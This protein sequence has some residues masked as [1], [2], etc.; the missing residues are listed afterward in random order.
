VV[1]TRESAGLRHRLAR[2]RRLRAHGEA[3]W[4]VPWFQ[5][6]CRFLNKKFFSFSNLFYKLQINF[7]S[8]Q[9]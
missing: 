8:N 7:N 4:A 5:P 2:P 1:R 3:G 6:N 9:I